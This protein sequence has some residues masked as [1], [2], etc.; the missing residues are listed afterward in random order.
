[1]TRRGKQMSRVA[2]YPQNNLSDPNL[3]LADVSASMVAVSESSRDEGPRKSREARG[4]WAG[5]L[6]VARHTIG[7]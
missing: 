5:S 7:T 1:M 3:I 6:H 4:L 2:A